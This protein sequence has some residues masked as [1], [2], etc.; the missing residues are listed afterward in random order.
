MKSVFNSAISGVLLFR[1]AT[2]IAIYV[3]HIYM[4]LFCLATCIDI[5][6]SLYCSLTRYGDN[7]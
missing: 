7:Q 6:M 1:L 4:S 2:Y 5:Y 3:T